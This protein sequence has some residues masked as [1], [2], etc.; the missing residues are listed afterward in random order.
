MKY[1]VIVSKRHKKLW[2]P[3]YV[4]DYYDHIFWYKEDAEAAC[5]KGYM[6]IQVEMKIIKRG[7]F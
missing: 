4:D 1:W 7:E 3:I 5:K 2:K 6:T